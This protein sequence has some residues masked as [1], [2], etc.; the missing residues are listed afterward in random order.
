VRLKPHRE[1]ARRAR[2]HSP[3]AGV[4]YSLASVKD[5]I[6]VAMIDDGIKSG[7]INQ[8]SVLIE[9][10]ERQHRIAL[11]FVAGGTGLE[12]NPDHAGDHEHQR[13]QAVQDSR[14]ATRPHRRPKGMKGAIAKAEELN[15]LIE[16]CDLQQ[17]SLFGFA[18]APFMPFGP[19]VRTELR[20]EQS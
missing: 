16:Q 18:M 19:S 7:A 8:D 12:T 20:A 9:P 15:K 3:Q 10:N 13:A 2:G 11:A 1:E 14:R 6:G 4:L 5:R 17:F